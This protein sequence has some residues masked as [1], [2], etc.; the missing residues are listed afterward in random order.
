MGWRA[1]CGAGGV[2][3]AGDKQNQTRSLRPNLGRTGA[4][5]GGGAGG[6]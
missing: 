6:R 3:A 5:G 4:R 2:C 1:G